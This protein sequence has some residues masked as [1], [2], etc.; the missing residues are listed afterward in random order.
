[1]GKEGILVEIVLTLNMD[2]RDLLAREVV[3]AIEVG[4]DLV[5][6]MIEGIDTKKDKIV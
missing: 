4:V 6:G 3:E 5:G 2:I 1:V